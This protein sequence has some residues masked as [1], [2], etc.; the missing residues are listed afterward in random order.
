M[1]SIAHDYW[2]DDQGR[3]QSFHRACVVCDD[4]GSRSAPT[5]A[6]SDFE[7]A[8]MWHACVARGW[9]ERIVGN[10]LQH[11]CPR[12]RVPVGQTLALPLPGVA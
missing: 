7:R 5:Y 6:E 3:R 4:C 9:S 10:R 1:I 12:H 11:V 2:K 8:M